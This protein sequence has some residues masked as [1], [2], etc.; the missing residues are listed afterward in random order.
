M[1]LIFCLILITLFLIY[2][3]FFAPST[4]SFNA[5]TNSSCEF[6]PWGPSKRACIDRCRVDRALWGGDAC[7]SSS[8]YSICNS[9]VD[10]D[11]CKW[12]N[13]RDMLEEAR[14]KLQDSPST[15]ELKIDIRGIPSDKSAIINFIHDDSVDTTYLLKYF[16]SA[17]PGSGVNIFKIKEPKKGFNNIKIINLTNDV[18]YSF[19][20]V[21]IILS[22]IQNMSDKVNVTPSGRINTDI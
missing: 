13:S 4:E 9:C 1:E 5:Q 2:V 15:M 19:V 17:R 22:K 16:E 8:C 21:P 6:I 20:I 11:K 3:Q 7:S 14:Q 10:K 18:T 12:L